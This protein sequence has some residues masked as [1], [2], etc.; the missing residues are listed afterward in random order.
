MIL[1]IKSESVIQALTAAEQRGAK[2]CRVVNNLVKPS[3]HL[4][5]L[6]YAPKDFAGA[7]LVPMKA[8]VTVECK[9]EW[10]LAARWLS[11]PP[12]S[13]PYPSG[14]LLCYRED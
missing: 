4:E 5:G 7:R 6:G 12:Y 1:I 3:Q 9:M 2:R 8:S 14:S 11:E 13:A 10:D